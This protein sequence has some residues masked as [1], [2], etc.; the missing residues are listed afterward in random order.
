MSLEGYII[1][2]TYLQP[3]SAHDHN[4]Q[5][6][7]QTGSITAAKYI[8]TLAWWLPPS[9]HNDGLQNPSMPTFELITNV[10]RL[11]CGATVELQGR[12][13]I[14][15]S[16]PHLTWHL[17]GILENERFWLEEHRKWVRRYQ[18]VSSDEGPHHLRGSM[19]THHK[20][21]S[22]G[23]GKDRVCISYDAM[24]CIYPAVSQIHTL[25]C[26]VYLHYASI[27]V[28]IYIDRLR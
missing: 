11:R 19:K 7:L 25:W 26:W 17:K 23:A 24:M 3:Q 8:S 10:T 1:K 18:M 15:N 28:C 14:N 13:P 9:S 21:M 12:Q 16:P 4:L 5:A 2:L 27:Y 20:C 6:H 22:Q